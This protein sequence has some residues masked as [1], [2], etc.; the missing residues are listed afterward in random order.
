MYEQ[1]GAIKQ[2][3]TR[4]KSRNEE[5]RCYY[6]EYLFRRNVEVGESGIRVPMFE[7]ERS[8]SVRATKPSQACDQI[9]EDSANRRLR[10]V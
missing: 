7:G 3:Q 5:L 4:G 8:I 1:C 6:G 2:I 9:S 10:H